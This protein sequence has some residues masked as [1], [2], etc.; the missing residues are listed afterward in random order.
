[1]SEVNRIGFACQLE[2]DSLALPGAGL[3][4]S[5]H[6][7]SSVPLTGTFTDNDE[8]AHPP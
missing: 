5:L 2:V 1:V 8:E 4:P 7:E 6:L 3:F